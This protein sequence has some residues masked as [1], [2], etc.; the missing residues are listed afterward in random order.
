M[1]KNQ[2]PLEEA[3]E[4]KKMTNC[5]LKLK[6]ISTRALC[7]DIEQWS[8]LVG[9]DNGPTN[10]NFGTCCCPL[11]ENQKQGLAFLEPFPTDEL[12]GTR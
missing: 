6:V 5:L 3:A 12:G 10:H 4:S 9:K 11:A 8:E 2:I 7:T 1:Q